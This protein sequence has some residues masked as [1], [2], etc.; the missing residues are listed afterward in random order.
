M[1][2]QFEIW[3]EVTES[4]RV[5][6]EAETLEEAEEIATKAY[7]DKEAV[8][9][10]AEAHNGHEKVKGIDTLVLLDTLEEVE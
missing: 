5:I 9:W 2:K 8:S 1:A 4:Y 7:E 10:I 6:F 3:Y